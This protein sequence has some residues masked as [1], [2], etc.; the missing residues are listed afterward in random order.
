[1]AW[2]G[3]GMQEVQRLSKHSSQSFAGCGDVSQRPSGTKG[4]GLFLRYLGSAR[5]QTDLTRASF[6]SLHIPIL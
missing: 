2:L 1:M 3:F 4:P 5:D 6:N